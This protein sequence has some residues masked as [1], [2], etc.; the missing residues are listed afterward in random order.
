[1][2]TSLITAD[3][4]NSLSPG[5]RDQ[6]LWDTKI[7]GFGVKVTPK[8]KKVFIL[9]YR[10]GGR[11]HKTRRYTIGLDGA[12]RPAAARSIAE[13][14]YAEIKQGRDVQGELSGKRKIAV[15]LAFKSY[16]ATFC[17]GP[18]MREWPKSWREGRR[19]L[20]NHA[21]PH[22]KDKPLPDITPADIRQLLKRLDDRP[23]TKRN[24]FATLSYL[25]NKSKKD[26]LISVS[27]LEKIDAPRPVTSRDRTL[28]NDELR[29]LMLAL[30]DEE[31]PYG[32]LVDDLLHLG[33]RRGE[34]AGMQWQELDRAEREWTI[35]AAR[36]KN[37]CANIVPLTP[38]AIAK[39]DRLAGGEK[40]PR[41][42]LVYPS[43]SK[44]PISGW[45]K[46]KARLDKAMKAEAKKAGA[47]IEPWRLHDLRRTFATNMQRMGVTHAAIEHLL[48]HR[49]KARTG[50]AKVYQTHDFK[51]EKR[52][53]LE[54][55][56]SELAR[57]TERAGAS[58]VV[59]LRA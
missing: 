11:G 49:E 27:P 40:W 44:T 41:S 54:R 15:E 6:F 10:L 18:M 16:V 4:V 9:Q 55:W 14:L 31:R 20:D 8:G 59:A 13:K 37:G 22:L 53:A 56:E 7:P 12:M 45:S 25:F 21:V 32:D 39:F 34:V 33:Q 47:T 28:S 51:P 42:G 52:K 5:D 35:P 24:L 17:D 46:L 58:N 30:K 38:R 29:W 3:S 43:R 19:C 50:I 26:G 57:L 1:M 36:A 2:P 48:N 23:A